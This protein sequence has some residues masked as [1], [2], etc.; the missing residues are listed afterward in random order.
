MSVP[1]WH[2]LCCALPQRL[3]RHVYA[4]R[5]DAPSATLADHEQTTAAVRV[6]RNVAIASDP[7]PTA[8]GAAG[9]VIRDAAGS[10]RLPGRVVRTEGQPPVADPAVN[11]AYD[12]IGI[13]LAFFQSVLQRHS[14]DGE[15][16]A[17]TA[18]VH[19]GREYPNAMWTGKEMIFGDGDGEHIRGFAQSLDIVAHELTHA[20]TQYIVARGLGRLQQGGQANLVGQAGALNESFS[21]VFATMVLQWHAR[22]D[23]HQASWLIG[24]GVLAPHIG[25][26]VRSLKNPGD[27]AL[28]YDDDDQA[29]DMRGYVEG[30]DAHVNSGI[31]NHAFYLAATE[32]GGRSWEQLGPIWFGAL[33]RLRH[34]ATFADAAAATGETA[35]RLHGAGSPAHRAIVSGW[36]KVKVLP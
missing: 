22:Q 32:L 1:H 31:P 18:S 27:T 7:G 20:I 25:R 19:F 33:G 26:A 8:A 14:L 15:G 2:C 6:Q 17:V 34:D 10:K 23:V 16:V 36:R 9:R 4:K 3:V 13:T 28:T 24:E 12:N 5:G 29:K 21:D 11:Q 35:A 30:G